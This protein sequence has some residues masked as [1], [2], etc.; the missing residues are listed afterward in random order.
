MHQHGAAILGFYGAIFLEARELGL[1][2]VDELPEMRLGTTPRDG[3]DNFI[4]SP[5]CLRPRWSLRDVVRPSERS[6]FPLRA[7]QYC[8]DHIESKSSEISE[9]VLVEWL[10]E[11]MGVNQP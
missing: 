6:R 4:P 8:H 1:E 7:Q 9:I 2:G 11:K 10:V 5:L 3:S